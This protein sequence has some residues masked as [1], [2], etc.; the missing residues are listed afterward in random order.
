MTYIHPGASTCNCPGGSS[1]S[2]GVEHLN[3]PGSHPFCPL[4]ASPALCRRLSSPG[5]RH[6]LCLPRCRHQHRPA[7]RH[8]AYKGILNNLGTCVG[9]LQNEGKLLVDCDS[10]G[11]RSPLISTTTILAYRQ[12]LCWPQG[13]ALTVLLSIYDE[14]FALA[15]FAGLCLCQG[16]GTVNIYGNALPKVKSRSRGSFDEYFTESRNR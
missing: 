4:E 11:G 8:P 9:P 14:R 5:S 6:L 12:I 10:G 1:S 15:R 2:L 3:E 16:S 13:P 7:P